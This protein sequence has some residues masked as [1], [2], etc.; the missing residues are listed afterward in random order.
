[1]SEEEEELEGEELDLEPEEEGD[2]SFEEDFEATELD[3]EML[4][5]PNADAA[6]ANPKR[7]TA[8]VRKQNRKI[9]EGIID[10][11]YFESEE[12][13]QRVY[14]ELKEGSDMAAAK[15]YSLGVELTE[16]D[17]VKHPTFGLGFVLELMSPTKVEVL[18]E[19]G[20]KKLVCNQDV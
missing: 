18:F 9:V 10:K 8:A 6:K 3:D 7:E 11:A 4:E 15:E 17:V 13:I 5:K 19:D 20:V 14:G 2:D 12:A 16:N 1:M